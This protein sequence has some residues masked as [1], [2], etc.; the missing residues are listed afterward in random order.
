MSS[1]AVHRASVRL[2]LP[3]C[4]PT[5]S[6][7]VLGRGALPWCHMYGLGRF[8]VMPVIAFD[9]SLCSDGE[10]AERLPY[11]PTLPGL[12][13]GA[14]LL[15][16]PSSLSRSATSPHCSIAPSC[17]TSA[18]PVPHLPS[19]TATLPVTPLPDCNP[20]CPLLPPLSPCMNE[21]DVRSHC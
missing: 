15:P 17:L 20:A 8:V 21:R 2:H 14:C 1:V 11:R 9:P 12:A 3:P 18:L 4:P 7:Y 5:S 16:Y 10:L 13:R 6:T 19:L